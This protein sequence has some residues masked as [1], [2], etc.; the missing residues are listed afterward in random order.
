MLTHDVLIVGGGITGLAAALKLSPVCDV[1]VVS[2]VHSMRSHSV[3]AQGGMNAALGNHPDGLDDSIE[4]HTFDTVKGSDYLA[5]QPAAELMCTEA[6]P[7]AYELEHMGVPF[8]R[9]PDGRMAQRPFGGAG[10]PRCCY[11]ADRTGHVILHT[12]YDQCLKAGIRFHH[13]WL[14]SSLVIEKNRVRG[15]VALDLA[16]GRFV[17]VKAK[18]VL[19]AT[20]GYGQVFRRTTNAYINHGSGIGIAY[21]AGMPL[22]DMEFVQFHPTTLYG[23]NVLMTEGAR[24][25]GGYLLN[26]DGKRFMVD[27]APSAMELAP[28]DIVAR[29]IQTEINQGRGVEG[30]FIHLDLRHLGAEKIMKRLPAI[31]EIS[32]NFVGVDPIE[33]PIPIIPAQHYSMGGI[34]CN[35]FGETGV[36]GMYAGGECSCI[37]VHGANRLGGN[38]L[39][40]TAVFGRIIGAKL[41]GTMK[42]RIAPADGDAALEREVKNLEERYRTW[43][44]RMS[45][46]TPYELLDRLK[47]VNTDH[48]GIFREEKTMRRGLELIKEIKDEA[49]RLRLPSDGRRFSQ[50]LVASIEL[51]PMID[52]AETIAL[53]AIERTETRG[54]HFR[55]DHSER[56]D[57]R[58][59]KHT[60]ATRG[61]DGPV[62]THK[63]VTITKYQPQKRVY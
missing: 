29:S 3:A 19:F 33:A 41:A 26:S 27:Y 55:T 34:D 49:G 51:E 15:I 47:N 16:T 50:P 57:A 56:D 59:L 7:T 2:M 1:A 54:S 22:K 61:E 4:R 8:S 62:L 21:R 53:G 25:E 39:L 40:E 13:E 20:G 30:K 45:G 52:V 28:R 24:G 17:P 14:V 32:M 60:V 43:A 23:T 11:A 36:E 5:D 46:P 10:V 63:K 37:S 48:F 31:R 35:E 42:S 38:S 9:F 58:W 44:G 12:H 18:V 6:V